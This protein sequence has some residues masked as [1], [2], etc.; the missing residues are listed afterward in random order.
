LCCVL[1]G[2]CTTEAQSPQRGEQKKARARQEAQRAGVG[3]GPETNNA[4][5]QTN[6]ARVRGGNVRTHVEN[7]RAHAP[8]G[9]ARTFADERCMFNVRTRKGRWRQPFRPWRVRGLRVAV[10]GSKVQIR[11]PYALFRAI[12]LAA[13][14]G[15]VV[16]S[17]L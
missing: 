7:V 4:R 15:T 1:K 13:T 12:S 2:V 10:R 14:G 17:A 16:A 8:F 3:L 11:A 5:A 6:N 9:E